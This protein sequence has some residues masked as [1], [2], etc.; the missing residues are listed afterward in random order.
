MSAKPTVPR[1]KVTRPTLNAKPNLHEAEGWAAR[2][3]ERQGEL[4]LR[5]RST[6]ALAHEACLMIG[7]ILVAIGLA[8]AFLL[9]PDGPFA[10]FAYLGS[11]LGLLRWVAGGKGSPAETPR[12]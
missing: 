1:G 4:R 5:I 9:L 6:A 2:H 12:Y 7:L 11:G 10:A 8:N 3:A